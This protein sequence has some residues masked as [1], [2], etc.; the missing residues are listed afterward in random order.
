MI[1]KNRYNNY[2][3]NNICFTKIMESE[4]L[5]GSD[6][7]AHRQRA[8]PV[9]TLQ[10][11]S[12][13]PPSLFCFSL[14]LPLSLPVSASLSLSHSPSVPLSYSLIA[15]LDVSVCSQ[16]IRISVAFI[17]FAL[18]TAMS[19]QALHFCKYIYRYLHIPEM[20]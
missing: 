4:N 7:E 15:L 3:K 13:H 1:T 5:M 11:S 19:F 16:L 12:S 9:M 10:A 17:P 2:N 8:F 18:F 14:F 20:R 6:T